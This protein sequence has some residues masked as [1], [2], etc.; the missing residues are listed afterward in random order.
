MLNG[1]K[2]CN[3]KINM[4]LHCEKRSCE[5][6]IWKVAACE[7]LWGIGLEVITLDVDECGSQHTQ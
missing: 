5:V 4:A 3:I 6:G 7:L 1:L 2:I